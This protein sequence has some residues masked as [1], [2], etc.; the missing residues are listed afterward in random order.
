M[1]RAL[2][3]V[4]GVASGCVA[5]GGA[6]VIEADLLSSIGLGVVAAVASV[7]TVG[8]YDRVP[9]ET[10]WEVTRWNGTF[11]G[12]T[13]L[14]TFL[15]LNKELSISAET[16]LVLQLLVLGIAW[17]SLLTGVLLVHEQQGL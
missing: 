10:E 9:S 8:Y 2:L 4:L 1:N 3:R 11:I 14:G 13:M 15:G 6:L 17:S 16:T 12:V 7:L 5:G